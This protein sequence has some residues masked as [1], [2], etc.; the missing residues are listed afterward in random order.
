M[1]VVLF[2]GANG[3]GKTTYVRLLSERLNWPIYRAFRNGSGKYK[4][5]QLETY[6]ALGIPANTFVDDIYLAD[7]FRTFRPDLVLDRSMPSALA[8]D[9]VFKQGTMEDPGA[10][11]KEWNELLDG[12]PFLFVWLS[13]PYETARHRCSGV[14]PTKTEHNGLEKVFR[15]VFERSPL[16]KLQINTSEI[17]VEDGMRAICR[18]L[19]S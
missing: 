11:L 13:A 7:F 1:T 3:V 5:G 15:R 8:Y 19:K 14:R 12:V 16:D 10:I 6:R 4:D 9:K 17:S 2:E 18:A